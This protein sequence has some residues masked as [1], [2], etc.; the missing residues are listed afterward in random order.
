MINVG[1]APSTTLRAR[2]NEAQA[3]N[4]T[5]YGGAGK[6]QSDDAKMTARLTRQAKA[7]AAKAGKTFNTSAEYRRWHA[8]QKEKQGMKEGMESE[9]DSLEYQFGALGKAVESQ[10]ITMVDVLMDDD[11][12]FD[13]STADVQD[14]LNRVAEDIAVM[15]KEALAQPAARRA[16]IKALGQGAQTYDDEG[17][18][19]RQRQLD[20]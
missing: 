9:S 17:K 1:I 4:D 8:K 11:E 14:I 2:L 18:M 6:G 10:I 7:A 16:V 5:E 12:E 13:P 20:V 19:S 3:Y 15:A